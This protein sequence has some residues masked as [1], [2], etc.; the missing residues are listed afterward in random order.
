MSHEAPASWCD[1]LCSQLRA[2]EF[3]NGAVAL[4]VDAFR[5]GWT[6]IHD[7]ETLRVLKAEPPNGETLRRIKETL[8]E[9]LVRPDGRVA[10]VAASVLS[11]SDDPS[12]IPILTVELRRH[13]ED[14]LAANN[15]MGK[16]LLALQN[17]GAE[18][19]S[20]TL[21]GADPNQIVREAQAYLKRKG[22]DYVTW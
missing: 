16:I 19:Y 3:H 8:L 5:W 11:R 21:C 22:Y 10:A 7:L 17:A 1:E 9:L 14:F 15:A 13:V 4:A 12:L 6:D 2:E 18:A 20:G